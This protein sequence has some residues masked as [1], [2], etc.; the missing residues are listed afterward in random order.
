MRQYRWDG[1]QLWWREDD[2]L[3]TWTKATPEETVIWLADKL[4]RLQ[5]RVEMLESDD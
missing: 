5:L 3:I 1:H 4:E 2:L